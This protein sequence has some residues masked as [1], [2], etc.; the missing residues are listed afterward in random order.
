MNQL[1]IVVPVYNSA[2]TLSGLYESIINSLSNKFVQ[3]LEIIF[4]D[5]GSIDSSWIEITK[6]VNIDSRVVGIKLS[7]NYGQHN[8]LLCGIRQASKNIIATVDDDLQHPLQ[9]LRGII[10]KLNEGYDLVYGTFGNEGYGMLRARSSRFAKYCIK[11]LTS[12]DVIYSISAFRVFR[13]ELRETFKN[14]SSPSVSIDVLL[15]WATS[16]IASVAVVQSKRQIGRSNYSLMKLIRHSFNLITGFTTLPL[17]LASFIGFVFSVLG[18]LMLCWIL[19][20]Y[21]IYGSIVPGFAFLASAITIFSGAQLCTMGI[22][23]EYLARIY[24]KTMEQP[25]YII[26]K[27][28]RKCS[29]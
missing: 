11:E 24:Q 17:Q 28:E 16:N 26:N 7:K 12:N 21:F 13:T 6:L 22:F 9:E 5:D 19:G 20:M 10:D 1:T 27:V 29:S 15:S 3:D 4:V 8:A 25:S 2:K 14:Y 23:G 18:V